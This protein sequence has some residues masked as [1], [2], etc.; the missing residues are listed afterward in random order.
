MA[1]NGPLP[2]NDTSPS[3]RNPYRD[4]ENYKIILEITEKKKI[5]TKIILETTQRKKENN[6]YLYMTT[7][8]GFTLAFSGD[9]FL[10][11]RPKLVAPKK[12]WEAMYSGHVLVCNMQK[13]GVLRYVLLLAHETHHSY[14]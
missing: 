12:V 2:R 3:H 10:K 11:P 7:Y 5:K 8:I 6:I 9:P 14:L 1:I 13:E 4:N